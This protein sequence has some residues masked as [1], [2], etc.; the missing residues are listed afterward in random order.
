MIEEI[1]EKLK[2]ERYR[3]TTRQTYYRI[4]MIF[5]KFFV[6]LDHKP[7]NW[8]QRLVLFAAFLVDDKLKS[9]TVKT[10]VAAIKGIL[11]EN[12]VKISEDAFVL[13][14]LTKACRIKNDH[15]ILILP[16]EKDFLHMILDEC[17]HYFNM[18]RNNQPYLQ[19]LYSAMLVTGYCGLL[20]VGEIT[21]GPH[22]IKAKDVHIGQNKEKFLFI[23][24]TSK[25]HD[26]GSCP[27]MVK[28]S[29]RIDKKKK[30]TKVIKH[31]PFSILRDY[32]NL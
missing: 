16:I 11:A 32:V 26:E 2:S 7:N 28:V 9:S 4:W 19:K 21:K 23:L 22:S 14:S 30:S 25:T 8:E 15:L 13:T 1:V 12:N 31:N 20:H 24:R 18:P 5:N 3:N 6:R 10:Y 29:H 27:Q 17:Q